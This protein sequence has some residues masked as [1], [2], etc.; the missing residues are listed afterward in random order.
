MT[1][2]YC[3]ATHLCWCNLI[4]LTKVVRSNAR[5]RLNKSLVFNSGH[6]DRLGNQSAINS[7]S[8]LVRRPQV[9]PRPIICHVLECHRKGEKEIVNQ[10]KVGKKNSLNCYS[11]PVTVLWLYHIQDSWCSN[12]SLRTKLCRNQAELCSLIQAL[13][14]EMGWS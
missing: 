12:V 7:S 9:W 1:K 8:V 4:F 10:V 3:D 6:H 11:L 5:I 14:S 13:A 2:L